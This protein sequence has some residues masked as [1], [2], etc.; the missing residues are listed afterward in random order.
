MKNTLLLLLFLCPQAYGQALQNIN[1]NYLY[2]PEAPFSFSTQTAAAH[3]DSILVA[4][5]LSI[6]DTLQTP[7]GRYLL[8]WE[9]R[10][11]RSE[12]E[13]QVFSPA[14]Q[15]VVKRGAI[16]GSFVIQKSSAVLCAKVIDQQAKTAW[17]FVVDSDGHSLVSGLLASDHQFVV[18]KY[19]RTN[20]SITLPEPAQ[21]LVSYYADNFPA[22]SPAFA[23]TQA[24]VNS[25]IKPDSVFQLSHTFTPVSTGLYLL[26]ADTTLAK[27]IA[28]RAE[29]DYPKFT[30][31]ENLADPLTYITT[32]NELDRLKMAKGDK[33]A[34][35][36]IVIGITGT[37][38][39]AKIFMR[40]YFRR[41]ELAN[42]HFT[43][44]KEGWKTDRGMVYI[45]YGK[46][47]FVYKFSDREV[48]E[49]EAEDGK[50]SFTFVKSS[51]LFDPNNFVLVRK[52]SYR[53]KWLAAI[54]LIR[55]ARF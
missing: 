37:T 54:D 48:W 6:D 20:T 28:F 26:Q 15:F 34:F 16:S 9:L 47:G 25:A 50:T 14:S 8:S 24:L 22:A 1:Y 10:E 45:I 30:S 33:K 46:P 51:T 13:G 43:S 2:D 19:L 42:R 7:V 36:K 31:I 35:D 41:V 39:R 49:Y 32:K 17:Y 29:V 52:K 38:E 44:Y 23:E 3:S 21:Q 27:G 4:F 40:N 5:K 12:K 53:D 11:S 55:N 18:Q